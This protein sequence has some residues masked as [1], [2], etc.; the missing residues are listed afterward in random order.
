LARL[1]FSGFSLALLTLSAFPAHAAGYAF[2][3]QNLFIGADQVVAQANYG[4]GIVFANLDTGNTPQ[5]IGFS[6]DF[7]NQGISNIDS[8]NSISCLGST[9]AN[10]SPGVAP[11]DLNGHGT[12][13]ASQMV[14]AIDVIGMQGV[15]PGGTVMTVQVLGASGSG[16]S[17]D[18]ANGIRYAAN[19]GAHVINLSL[20]P[21]APGTGG[22]SFYQSVASA[23]NY[24]ATKGV[25]VVFAGGN[26]NQAF[27]GN[28]TVTGFTDAALQRMLFMGST[29]GNL[30][31]SSFSNTP[32]TSKF[33]STTGQSRNTSDLWLM[34]YG[35][36]IY[37]AGIDETVPGYYMDIALASGTSMTAPQG[38]GAIGLLLA[39][40]PVLKTNG[41]AAKILQDNAFDIGAAGTDGTFGRGFMSLPLA[42]QASGTLTA[43]TASGASMPVGELGSTILSGGAM[44]ALPQ[45]SSQLSSYT[46][47]DQYQRDFTADLSG[48]VTARR[49]SSTLSASVG[50][51]RT[52]AVAARLADGSSFAFGTMEETV[53]DLSLPGRRE[54]NANWF[55]SFHGVHGLS[56]AAGHG[57]PASSSF[58]SV[59]WGNSPVAATS[60]ELGVARSL[61][62]LGE[63]GTFMAAGT[64]IGPNARIAVSWSQTEAAEDPVSSDWTMPDA[65]TMTAGMSAGLT[66]WWKTGATF[67]VL[68]ERHGLMGT[69]YSPHGPLNLGSDNMSVSAGVTSI[70]SLTG[71]T[72]IVLE[73]A[74]ARSHGSDFAGGIISGVSP[75]Y[76]RSYGAALVR[77]NT[78]GRGDRLSFAAKAPLTVF[79]GT[80]DLMNVSVD[81]NGSP[82]FSTSR[83]GLAPGGRELSFTTG[84]QS[85][86]VDNFSWNMSL[87]AS[88]DADNIKGASDVT[89]LAGIKFTF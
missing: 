75:L 58:T 21:T 19:H 22:A 84:Y 34:A 27:V 73:A 54:D 62:S 81:G 44:G 36:H 4:K 77:R 39:R 66:R 6:P 2:S 56:V 3:Y 67:S 33:T 82:V 83:V 70:F 12:F 24:A 79:S 64:R 57:Y 63:G 76:A 11:I 20:G 41:M 78:F 86:V 7:N 61:G 37:A 35:Q 5:W 80:A 38:S 10:C 50:A 29:N 15:A 13:T 17:N 40:W 48:L 42:F 60:Y 23:V 53:A 88:R 85:P 89:G 8:V 32:G 16:S 47:F 14:G 30:Q 18:V 25:Y 52:K 59:L 1:S 51:P 71:N 87:E 31:K 74:I 49:P 55:A 45:L 26:E 72:D 68:D 9:S 46:V 69:S 28:A 43:F 65:T